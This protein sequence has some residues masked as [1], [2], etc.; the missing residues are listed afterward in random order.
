LDEPVEPASEER[1]TVDPRYCLLALC[2]AVLANDASTLAAAIAGDAA[3]RAERPRALVER[4]EKP[5]H[6]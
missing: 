1:T 5:R 3:A 6:A 2:L 4:V